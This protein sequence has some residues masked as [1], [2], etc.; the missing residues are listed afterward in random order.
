MSN[1]FYPL[2]ENPYRKKDIAQAI[3]VL[4]SSKLTSGPI[5][6]KFQQLFSKKLSVNISLD[7]TDSGLDGS[8]VIETE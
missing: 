7:F 3:K 5:T 4:K 2:I 6:N 8:F 1:Y